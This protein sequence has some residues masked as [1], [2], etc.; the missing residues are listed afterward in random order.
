MSLTN[1]PIFHESQKLTLFLSPEIPWETKTLYFHFA[2]LEANYG[3]GL[4]SKN[5]S[6]MDRVV[7]IQLT[8]KCDTLDFREASI[9]TKAN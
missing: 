7:K 9:N 3:A 2:R 1:F 6:L 4:V 8:P 5:I